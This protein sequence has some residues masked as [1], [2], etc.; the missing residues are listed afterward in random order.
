MKKLVFILTISIIPLVATALEALVVLIPGA[1][2]SGAKIHMEHTQGALKL[3]GRDRY[4]GKFEEVLRSN[5][6]KHIVCP[7]VE[8]QDHRNIEG[9]TKDCIWFI[10]KTQGLKICYPGRK[11]NVVLFGHSMGGL[12]ARMIASNPIIKSC[13]HSVTSLASPH[14]GSAMADFLL[15]RDNNPDTNEDIYKLLIDFF[16]LNPGDMGYLT[17]LTMKRDKNRSFLYKAQDTKMS[18]GVNYYSFTTSM[19]YSTILPIIV[20]SKILSDELKK[21][22][23]PNTHDGFVPTSSMKH[24]KVLNHFKADH[25]TSA[26][27]GPFRTLY[28]GCRKSLKIVIPHLIK[29][30]HL[31]GQ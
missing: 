23:L 4:Y 20:V 2:S 27:I 11:R 12:I 24:G 31:A 18:R 14:K 19:D 21:M 22:G 7:E 16:N 29:Q 1:V 28:S 9:R 5:N 6:V 26:C 17:Q 8:D 15:D 3:L 13:I 25:F 30:Y 10:L